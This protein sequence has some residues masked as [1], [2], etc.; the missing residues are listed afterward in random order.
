MRAESEP[1][2]RGEDASKEV[3]FTYVVHTQRLLMLKPNWLDC[4]VRHTSKYSE[5]KMNT[6]QKNVENQS[7]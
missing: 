4:S 2:S 1:Q 6:I 5:Y 7:G 3:Y